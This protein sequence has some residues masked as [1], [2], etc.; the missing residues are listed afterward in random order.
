MNGVAATPLA[1]TSVTPTNANFTLGV[2]GG[3]AS[4]QIVSGAFLGG[5]LGA[6]GNLAIYN[7]L[8]TYMTAVGLA[9]L[10]E[11]GP[12]DLIKPTPTKEPKK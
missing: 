3:F 4:S 2:V 5:S 9:R 8:R 10:R 1:V 6:A 12:P 11:N 7:R